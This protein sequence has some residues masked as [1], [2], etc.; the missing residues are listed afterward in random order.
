MIIGGV[1]RIVPPAFLSI[2]TIPQS[3]TGLLNGFATA[4]R[5]G[6]FQSILD[7]PIVKAMTKALIQILARS[8]QHIILISYV[9]FLIV[10]IYNLISPGTDGFLSKTVFVQLNRGGLFCSPRKTH[11]KAS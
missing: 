7:I 1:Q 4:H 11:Q 8:W 6:D 5:M 2:G 3:L 10:L 9:Y